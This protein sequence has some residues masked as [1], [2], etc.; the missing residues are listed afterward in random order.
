MSMA[1][2]AAKRHKSILP[3]PTETI[4]VRTITVDSV[5]V[6]ARMRPLGDIGC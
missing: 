6:G 3:Q 1:T 5:K 4:K 2:S